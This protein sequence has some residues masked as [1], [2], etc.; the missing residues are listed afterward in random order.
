[1]QPAGARRVGVAPLLLLAL[2][3]PGGA[4]SA[5]PAPP[6]RPGF[7]RASFDPLVEE[8]IRRGAYPGAA[9]VIGRH[10]TVLLA[11]GYG[12]LTWS[13]SSPA[14]DVDSTFYD[15]ASLTKVIATTP[16]L[17]VLVERGS[18]RL[19]TPVATYLPAFRGPG[20]A[21]ITVRQLLTHTS[22]LRPTLPLFR[23]ARD[24][25]EALR[26]VLAQTPV[27]PPGTR[28]IYS[29][30]NAI[31]LGEIVRRTSGEPLAV[32]A[33]RE[34]LAPLGLSHALFRP[35]ARLRSRVAPTGVWH[36]HA[37]AGVVNDQNAAKLG[38]VAGHAGLFATAAD[39]ARFAQFMLREGVLADGGRLLRAETVH[40]FT[41]KAAD[42]GRGSE[43]RALGW[44]AVPTGES[45]SSAGTLFGPR[46][47]GHTGWTGTSLWIDPARDLFVVLLTNRAYAPRAR[48]SFTVLKTVRGR[49]A[50]AAARASDAP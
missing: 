14:A 24:S 36:G 13:P 1:V 38:G 19:D 50:D 41:T 42:F 20:T 40:L 6:A 27:A 45:V 17:M 15:L 3:G 29:D 49:V 9:L 44:Q 16:A 26:L 31:L 7:T 10:D 5:P 30:L 46:S 33:T 18:I 4:A 43:A 2:Q 8:G 22:G 21:G 39:V 34:V 35:P 11:C 37:V 32:F 48:R 12:H 28:V 47:Y 23:E 25:V